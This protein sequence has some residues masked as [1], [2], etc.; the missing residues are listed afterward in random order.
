MTASCAGSKPALECCTIPTDSDVTERK[1]AQEEN[2]KLEEQL[3]QA[4]KM[5]AVGRLAGGIAHDF[6]NLLMVIQSNAEMMQE[7]LT[8][9]PILSQDVQEILNAS[10]RAAGLT[11]QLLSFSRKQVVR[12]TM[13]DLRA[14]VRETAV[15]LER[16]IGEN[17]ELKVDATDSLWT[18]SADRDQI[19]QVFMNLSV[20]ARDAMPKGG[21]ITVTTRN[22]TMNEDTLA[23]LSH[24]VEPGDY[25]ELSV[26]DTGIGMSAEVREH[27]FD[28]FFTTKGLGHGTGLGLATVY[29]IVEQCGGYVWAESEEGKGSCFRVF[30]PRVKGATV[31][32]DSAIDERCQRG[33]ETILIAEDADSLR[34]SISTFMRG[35]GYTVLGARSGEEALSIAADYEGEIEVLLTDV[36]MPKMGGGELSKILEGLRPRLKTIYMSGYIDEVG[37]RSGVREKS[38]VFLQKPF[39]LAT[40]AHKIREVIGPSLPMIVE[41]AGTHTQM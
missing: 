22:V 18:V 38:A 10:D 26:A 40:L 31:T 27:V 35:L 19:V 2:V 21:V 7:R 25:V 29:A 5:E 4:Q 15:M 12:P 1:H 23:S 3:R 6:N 24:F 17:V 37:E 16:L 11:K 8:D 41:T 32:V 9:Q 28:P 33:T 14:I 39:K 20:N 30:L 34:E 13:L 36:V